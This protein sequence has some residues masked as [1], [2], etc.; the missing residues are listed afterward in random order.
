[1]PI[2]SRRF[3]LLRLPL[4]LALVAIAAITVTGCAGRRKPATPA[5]SD[6][7]ATSDTPDTPASEPPPTDTRS[8][9]ELCREGAPQEQALLDES[10]RVLAETFCGATLWFDGLFGGKPDVENARAV[11]GRVELSTLYTQEE[12]VEP[13]AR[14]R[15]KYDLPTLKKRFNL[16]LGREDRDDFV[17]G[18]EEGFAVRS[19]V[20]SVEDEDRW[21][22]GLG[23]SPPGRWKD[24]FDVRVGLKLS[25]ESEVFVQGRFRRNVFFGEKS[26]WRLRETV[27][28]ENRDGFGSTTSADFDHIL[29]KRL[30]FHWG[31]VATISEAT[32]GADWR[33]ATVLY[34]NLGQ[35]S[36]I[37]YEVFLR[38]ATG[39]DVKLREYGATST[40]RRPLNRQWLFGELTA[41]YTWPRRE[42]DEPRE[43][44]A[45]IGIGFELL[46]GRNPY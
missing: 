8:L 26:V 27:F 43:G 45:L 9:R 4:L 6:T 30:L 22:A 1:M 32:D 33:S 24:R 31:T 25:T 11:S 20:F 41:G 38:G 40:Y 19:S 2:S 34:Q 5:A 29:G 37:A 35:R 3:P 28:Y 12:G 23:Y 16:F 13:K 42:R 36:A 15:L 14:L 44:S 39:R 18:R 46:F 10:R 21:L 17:Q 7:P